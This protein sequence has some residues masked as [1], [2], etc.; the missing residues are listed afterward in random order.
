[1]AIFGLAG[2]VSRVAVNASMGLGSVK[3]A[4]IGNLVEAGVD[5]LLA[6]AGYY[7]AGLPGAL[8]GGSLGLAAMLPAAGRI[9][10]LCGT[11][12]FSAYM[13]SIRVLLPG[14]SLATGVLLLAA[15]TPWLGAWIGACGVAG[16]VALWQLRKIHRGA[17]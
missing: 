2:A 6:T 5:V 15:W 3:G 7:A 4:A 9:A 16:G 1:M 17:W 11:S 10:S 8:I 13:S 12:F 14:L